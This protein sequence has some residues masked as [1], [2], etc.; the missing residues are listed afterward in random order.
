MSRT[1]GAIAVGAAAIA[2]IAFG[3]MVVPSLNQSVGPGPSPTPT[4]TSSSRPTAT[5]GSD[6]A[7]ISLTGQLA[8]VATVEGNTD[9]YLINA[10]RSGLARLTDDP[11]ED[12]GPVWLADGKTLLFSRRTQLEPELAELFE[13]DVETGTERQLTATGERAAGPRLSPDGT[14]IAYEHAAGI[15]VMNADGSNQHRVYAADAS[16][17]LL[18]WAQDGQNL[19]LR[20]DATLEIVRL[21]IDTGKLTPVDPAQEGFAGALSPDGTT[22]AFQKVPGGLWL[23]AS[24][25]SAARHLFGDWTGVYGASWAPDSRHVLFPQADGW[26][27]VIATDGTGLTRWFEGLQAAPRP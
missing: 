25:G 22:L 24:D 7:P 21:S 23:M 13:V 19:Y 5:P 3:V 14:Q 12:L 4:A 11:G 9:I 2:L 17:T 10:D 1:I 16:Y 27:Y 20:R 15:F 6:L 26:L 18:V 8:L